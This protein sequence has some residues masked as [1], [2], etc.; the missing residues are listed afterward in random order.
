MYPFKLPTLQ[1]EYSALEPYIDEKTM[2][3]HHAKHHQ[4]YVD[5]LNKALE[6]YPDLQSNSVEELLRDI[7]LVPEDIRQLVINHGGGHFNHAFFW[8]TL[9][10]KGSKEPVGKVRE[11]IEKAFGSVAQFIEEFT[12]SATKLFGS[13]WTWLA[14]D[15]TGSNFHI[16]NHS[17]QENP[18]LH[19]HMPVLGLDVWEHAYYLKYQ[20]RRAEYIQSFWNVIDWDKVNDNFVK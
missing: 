16:H 11:E 12:T 19:K 3:I 14:A 9:G 4:A 18:L 10:T 5:N 2:E 17:N 7:D 6:N 20:N 13:G 1:F 8:T 15:E